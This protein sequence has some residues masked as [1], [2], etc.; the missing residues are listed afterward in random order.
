VG[1]A[2]DHRV[3]LGF[4]QRL[5]VGAH[6]LDDGVREREPALDDAGQVGCLD[7]GDGQCPMLM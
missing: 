4:L 3:D 1:A 2:E 7:L 6:H 5:A